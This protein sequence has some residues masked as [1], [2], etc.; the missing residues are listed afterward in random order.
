MVSGT[1]GLES[2]LVLP[3]LLELK[4]M[5]KDRVNEIIISGH[6]LFTDQVSMNDTN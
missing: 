3:A 2:N 6:A 5:E 4:V 1:H